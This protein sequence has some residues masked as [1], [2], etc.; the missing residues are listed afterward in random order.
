MHSIGVSRS[1]EKGCV[2][3]LTSEALQHLGFCLTLNLSERPRQEN[4]TY[5]SEILVKEP[6]NR[7]TLSAKACQG[8]LNR[9][10]RRGKDL[11]PEL[12]AALE[13]Q[14][15]F[16]NEQGNQGGGKGILLQHE[17]IPVIVLNEV[18]AN[19]QGTDCVSG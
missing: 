16:K 2:Y 17:R 15:R 12:K 4:R 8:I 1:G 18:E 9:A 5:L 6:D 13:E 7:Y 14:S 11:P 10:E 3:W 19:E